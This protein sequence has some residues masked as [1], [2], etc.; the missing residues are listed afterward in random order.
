MDTTH[1]PNWYDPVFLP[2]TTPRLKSGVEWELY[3]PMA[4]IGA[5]LFL[6]GAIHMDIYGI[7]GALACFGPV[8]WLLREA[9]KHDGQWTKI[10]FAARR[11]PLVRL[12][13]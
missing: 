6:F 4:T 3:V 2:L 9:A 1:P 11:E 13:G 8:K 12:P 10:H 7:L 5:L